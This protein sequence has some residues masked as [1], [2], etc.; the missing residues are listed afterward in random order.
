MIDGRVCNT[1]VLSPRM[2]LI[3]DVNY[4]I[5]TPSMDPKAKAS[6]VNG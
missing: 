2:Y 1:L 4:V 3:N 5:L 6:L